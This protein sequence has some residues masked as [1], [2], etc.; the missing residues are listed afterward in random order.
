MDS[1]LEHTIALRKSTIVD[2]LVADPFPKVDNQNCRS[3]AEL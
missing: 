2:L 3:S 1:L